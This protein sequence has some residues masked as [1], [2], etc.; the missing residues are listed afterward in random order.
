MTLDK[1]LDVEWDI[2]LGDTGLTAKELLAL[3][4]LKAPLV[5]VRGQW[6]QLSAAE[7]QAALELQ[8]QGEKGALTGRELLRLA[9]GAEDVGGLAVSSVTADGPLGE[10]L[11]GLAQGDRSRRCRYR[12]V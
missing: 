8:R 7:I 11:A 9:L 3:A 5:R 2:V 6:V 10:L 12:P 1:V 4:K